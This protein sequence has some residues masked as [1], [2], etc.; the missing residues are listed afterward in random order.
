VPFNPIGAAFYAQRINV[1]INLELTLTGPRTAPLSGLSARRIGA[2]AVVQVPLDA[3][4][5]AF[6]KGI[7]L[8]VVCALI[9]GVQAVVSRRSV[10]DGLSAADVTILRFIVA[11]LV[12]LPVALGVRPVVVGELGWKRALVLTLLA[13]APYTLILVGGAAFA[14]A[15]HNAVITPG[16]IPVMAVLLG[17]LVLGQRPGPMKVLGI[18]LILAGIP[19]FSW[20][21]LIGTPARAGVWRGDLLFALSSVMWAYFGLLAGRWN[22]RAVAATA[23]IAI[24]SLL[25]TPLWAMLVPMRLWGASLAAILLQAIYQGLLVGVLATFLYMR[26]VMLL[27]SVR[28]AL[29]LPLVPIVTALTGAILLGENPSPLEFAGMLLVVAGMALALA[30]RR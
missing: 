18:A 4:A 8:G 30:S 22:V 10:I 29:F 16:L 20:D 14:P 1:G 25:G 28:A 13:G 7:G 6:W 5:R 12:L 24:L 21:A 26:V 15:L 27:G 9:W 23:S 11:S 2:S 17:L 19:V 3:A